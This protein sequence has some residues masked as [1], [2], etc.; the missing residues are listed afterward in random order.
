MAKAIA[1][2]KYLVE[3]VR[4]IMGK[5]YVIEWIN[6]ITSSFISSNLS[7]FEA[8]NYPLTTHHCFQLIKNV[9]KLAFEPQFLVKSYLISTILIQSVNH[10]FFN[11]THDTIPNFTTNFIYS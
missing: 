6:L 7:I 10:E 2:L 11:L 8:L 5:D 1:N 3:A 4:E 9:F